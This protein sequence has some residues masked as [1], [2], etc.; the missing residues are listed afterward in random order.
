MSPVIAEGIPVVAIMRVLF[1]TVGHGASWAD[2]LHVDVDRSKCIKNFRAK[3]KML[4]CF[5][6]VNCE[7]WILCLSLRMWRVLL[8]WF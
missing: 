8:R 1:F 2:V 3:F 6:M 5:W 7:E 4:L